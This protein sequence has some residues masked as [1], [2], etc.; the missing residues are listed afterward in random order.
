M[1]GEGLAELWQAARIG[2]PEGR[3]RG[4]A[5]RGAAA[6]AAT[7]RRGNRPGR[8]PRAEVVGE[9][10]VQRPRRLAQALLD[11]R[12]DAHGRALAHREVALGRELAVGLGDDAARD[13]ERGRER[14]GGRQRRARRDPPGLDALAQL[15]LDLLVQGEIPVAVER[16]TG[17]VAAPRPRRAAH[18]RP[19]VAPSLLPARGRRGNWRRGITAV[20]PTSFGVACGAWRRSRSSAQGS[21]GSPRRS[22]APRPVRRSCSTTLTVSPAAARRS[23]DAPHKANLGPH[24]LYSDGALWGWLKERDLLPPSTGI[25]YTGCGCAGA[26]RSIGRRRSR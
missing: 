18:G 7:R 22:R 6:I 23:L 8:G 14:P 25:P 15:A 10:R 3:E 17:P 26:A 12:G 16:S 21:R 11:G 19:G 20:I 4:F 5:P 13:A 1:G 9:R 24:V 2:L